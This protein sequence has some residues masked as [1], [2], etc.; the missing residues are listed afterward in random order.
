[1]GQFEIMAISAEEL[2]PVVEYGL[3]FLSDCRQILCPVP[4]FQW[5]LFRVLEKRGFGQVA[6][7]C[8]LAKEPVD[9]VKRTCLI[10]ASA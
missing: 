3:M 4:E 9:R 2:E 1:M 10:P 8:A 7:G 5:D 6:K